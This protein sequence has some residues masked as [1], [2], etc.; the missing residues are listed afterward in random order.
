MDCTE[1]HGPV[2]FAVGIY[3]VSLEANE[4]VPTFLDRN[5]L[6]GIR[7]A[8]ESRYRLQHWSFQFFLSNFV[9]ILVPWF[10]RLLLAVEL[11]ATFGLNELCQVGVS[12]NVSA[13]H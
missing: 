12:R 2:S 5:R 8:Q 3:G 7:D 4:C 6:F 1:A 10:P 13:H 9:I 11:L